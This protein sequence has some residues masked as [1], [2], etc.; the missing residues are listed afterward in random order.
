MNS[1]LLLATEAD[2]RSKILRKKEVADEKID[3]GI[4]QGLQRTEG[5]YP[6]RAAGGGWYPGITGRCG[7]P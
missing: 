2:G 6:D 7:Y 3:Q 5:F 1:L 4:P